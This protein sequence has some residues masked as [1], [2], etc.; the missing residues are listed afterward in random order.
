MSNDP[1][2]GGISLHAFGV[3]SWRESVDTSSSLPT[4]GN[5]DGDARVCRDTRTVWVWGAGG[6]Q[7]GASGLQGI[8]GDKGDKGDKGDTG[9]TGAAGVAGPQGVKGDP[10]DVGPAGSTGAT[11]AVGNAGAQGPQG[12][13]G[14][15]GAQ[16]I[17]GIKGD[18][19]AV[20]ATGAQGP[21]GPAPSGAA[22]LVLATPD[23]IPGISSLRALVPLD[24]PI[25]GAS[26]VSHSRGA[27][28][29]PGSAQGHIRYLSEDAQWTDPFAGPPL[30]PAT[31]PGLLVWLNATALNLN[32]GDAISSFTDQSGHGNHF[33]QATPAERP[34][35]KVNIV[36]GEPVARFD[37]VDDFLQ[38][39]NPLSLSTFSIFIVFY[40]S[41]AGSMIYEHSP[42]VNSNP[43]SFLFTDASDTIAVLRGSNK[44]ARDY[45]VT[46]GNWGVSNWIIACHSFGGTHRTHRLY[47]NGSLPFL[48][49][50]ASGDPGTGLVSDILY[51][52]SRGG[53]G[54][55]APIDVPDVLVFTPQLT[56]TQEREV[57][58]YLQ[59]KNEL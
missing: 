45:V 57:M 18:T 17:Q 26:G 31:Y 49:P 14:L 36:G 35:F 22:N 33:V 46:P 25:F 21:A 29:D 4:D 16:G 32:D 3:K 5:I 52:A 59:N 47:V 43:G 15:T 12:L 44:T 54:L 53:V 8:Q 41:S 6:W 30:S 10:G 34:I 20:G 55:F 19:G 23:G 2:V 27:V 24:I 48:S 56:T 37:G 7:E 42:N 28:P 58:R 40:S 50:A 1:T 11:G 51:L 39:T 9:N 13:T 38:S